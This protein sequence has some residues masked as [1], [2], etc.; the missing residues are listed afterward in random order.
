MEEYRTTSNLTLSE[1]E[2]YRDFSKS[3][4]SVKFLKF[5]E[6]KDQDFFNYELVSF[7]PE[8]IQIR[9]NFSDPLLVS[10]GEYA[11]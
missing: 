5:T 6:E 2:E 3:V 11:D 1:Q 9:L 10:Q 7:K 4:L 8:G